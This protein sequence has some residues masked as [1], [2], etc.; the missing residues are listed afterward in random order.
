[1]SARPNIVLIHTHDTGRYLGVYGAPVPTPNLSRMAREGVLFRQAFCASPGCSASRASLMTSLMPHSNGTVGLCHRGFKLND[2]KRHLSHLLRNAGYR[3]QLIGFQHEV[4]KAS[5]NLLGYDD[6]VDD[7]RIQRH[8]VTRAK[9]AVDWLGKAPKQPF[10]LNVG[11]VETH[12]PFSP[13]E[14]PEDERYVNPLPWLPDDPQVRKDLAELNT[15]VRHVDDGVGLILKALEKHKLEGNT[16]VIYTTDHGVPF[17]R[18]KATLFDAGIGVAL[19]MRG[20]G[21]FEG[22]QVIDA[23]VSQI[24]ILPSLFDVAKIEPPR[25]IQ[26]VSLVPLVKGAR[27]AVR[28]E[29]FGEITYH[30]AYDPARCV[31]TL[32]HKY[33]RFYEK[34]P[35]MVLPNVDDSY[36]KTLLTDGH[37][38]LGARPKEM[39]FDLLADPQEYENVAD[40]SEHARAKKDLESRLNSWMKKTQDPI[41]KGPVPLPPGGRTT[42]IDAY[43]PD[44]GL[45]PIKSAKKERRK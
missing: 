33:I 25:D 10:F 21:G 22:G 45:R 1:M 7:E 38:P 9:A 36:S 43:S 23:L 5:L 19:I 31:R 17:P 12:R 2:P 8:S 15:D 34:Y 18:A 29:I 20:P 32:R 41:L 16:I 4:E 30:A 40:W 3:T 35:R 39:L 27:T 11:F 24:D 37:L 26:G 14:A 6:I 13:V 44:G 42:P 28:E